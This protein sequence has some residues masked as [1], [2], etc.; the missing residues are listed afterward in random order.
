LC[1]NDVLRGTFGPPSGLINCTIL[2][3]LRKIPKGF[4]NFRCTILRC[5]TYSLWITCE[6]ITNIMLNSPD[7]VT[8]LA[9]QYCNTQETLRVLIVYTGDL[10]SPF[11]PYCITGSFGPLQVPRGTH[12]MTYSISYNNGSSILKGRPKGVPYKC[13]TGIHFSN[14]PDSGS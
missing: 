14:F 13:I 6:P 3:T 4:F 1:G 5:M 7:R 8:T 2:R 9:T 10:R 11:I 12:C